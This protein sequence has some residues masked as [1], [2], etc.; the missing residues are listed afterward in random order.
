VV[1]S[2]D[3][4]QP[5][6]EVASMEDL[7]AASTARARFATLLMSAFATLA[8]IL[9]MLGI[10]AVASYNVAERTREIG[11]RIAFGAS[12]GGIQR[13]LLKQGLM[14]ALCGALI[15]AGASFAVSRLLAGLL[16]AT[17]PDDPVTFA[18]VA[19]V[20]VGTA[21]TACY[22]ATRRATGMDPMQ[23]LRCD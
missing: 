10:Y 22:L 1:L 9:A 21:L 19:G 20:L 14:L 5:L 11:I 2:L 12:T 15:G 23:A 7:L 3:K 18:A 8:L 17:K 13:M 16:F 4:N 6:A